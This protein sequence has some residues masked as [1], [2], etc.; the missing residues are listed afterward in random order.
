MHLHRRV[1][2]DPPRPGGQRGATLVLVAGFLVA[3]VLT[4]ALAIE[5]GRLYAAQQNVHRAANLAAIET[6][7]YVGG[8]RDLPDGATLQSIAQQSV[9]RNY[10]NREDGNVPTV[11]VSQPGVVET[12]PSDRQFLGEPEQFDRP[13]AVALTVT[14][15]SYNSL[16]PAFTGIGGP[17]IASAAATSRP[18]ATIGIGSTLLGINPVLLNDLLGVNVGGAQQGDLADV[19]VSIG[20]LVDISAG[21]VTRQQVLE[22]SLNE[23]LENLADAVSNP[24]AGLVQG[25]ADLLPIDADAAS[26]LDILEVAGPVGR[27][28]SINAGALLNAAAQLAAIQRD[29]AV[30]LPLNIS[31]L[32]PLIGSVSAQLRLLEP[33]QFKIGPPG[34]RPDGEYYTE[35]KSAQVGVELT[36][37]LVDF[38]LGIP[39]PFPL[40]LLSASIKLL[41]LPLVIQGAR[42]EAALTQIDCANLNQ[43]FHR[44]RMVAEADTLR[45]GVG[46]LEDSDGDGD[47]EFVPGSANV[48]DSIQV[49][50]L[51]FPSAVV[52]VSGETSLV[53]SAGSPVFEVDDPATDL[54]ATQP[55]GSSLTTQQLVGDLLREL[56][57]EVELLGASISGLIAPIEN[58]LNALLSGILTP[59]LAPVLDPVLAQLG[60]S[61][62]T[63]EAHLQDLDV[64]RSVVFCSERGSGCMP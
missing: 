21:A 48:L 64:N 31:G 9:A 60:V 61:L 36:V 25:V 10:A 33:A 19:E 5:V 34:I 39:G 14:D 30:T 16:F 45:A 7:R 56:D 4:M 12:G 27:D 3:L 51:S 35:V 54:P 6:A 13:S 11:S 41:E 59:V 24:V 32:P 8:C 17:R 40:G 44:V 2:S 38:T 49:S 47:L 18:E 20:D 53:S 23:A 1:G 62:G 46:T 22:T 29:E 37:D 43:P 63:G 52:T 57:L 50:V 55:V 15:G 42:G 28:L 26:L 58:S